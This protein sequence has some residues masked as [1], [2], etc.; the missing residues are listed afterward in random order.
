MASLALRH[1]TFAGDR[2]G[3]AQIVFDPRLTVVY[4][5]SD[6]GK[7]FVTDSLDYMLGARKLNVIPEAEGYSQILLGLTLPDGSV[8]TLMRGLNSPRIKVFNEDIRTL[9]Y[10]AADLSLSAQHSP[11]SS[12][13]LSR[14]LLE[15]IGLDG[16]LISTNATGGTK[17]LSFRDLLH[18]CL[19]NETRMI[20]K[21]PPA[22]RS[23]G[24]SGQTACR[25]AVKILLTGRGEPANGTRPTPGQRRVHKGKIVLLDD[26]VLALQRQLDPTSGN[27]AELTERLRR[28]LEHQDTGAVSLREV[29]A[30][31]AQAT[32]KRAHL[33]VE[34]AQHT[35]RRAEINNLLGR[36]E[37]LQRQYNSDLARLTMVTEA[38]S[39]LAYFNGEQRDCVLCGADPE[40]QRAHEGE[41][42][43]LHA[44]VETESLKTRQLLS[45]LHVTIEG[46]KEQR[47]EVAE[48]YRTSLATTESVD[49]V[50][51]RIEQEEL[52]PLQNTAAELMTA[53]SKVEHELGLHTRIQELE[54]VRATL[55]ADG[56]QPS[57]SPGGSIPAGTV[58]EFDRAIT[59]ALQSWQVPTDGDV[60][61][62]QYTGELFVGDRAR[63]AHGKGMRAVLH[64]AFVVALAE[65]CLRKEHSHPGFVVLDSPVLNYRQPGGPSPEVGQVPDNVTDRFY[66]DLFDS[67]RGQA[68][69]VENGDPPAGIAGQAQVYMFSR[70]PGGQRFGFFPLGPGPDAAPQP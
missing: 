10:R 11:R 25:S 23:S 69:V 2:R 45:D 15:R 54:D 32:A 67:F 60:F 24:T 27:Q 33:S 4:G 70:D 12:K 28:I 7:S 50:I 26:L 44:A 58:A 51:T 53:R 43:A 16:A 14:Y 63:T 48:Q 65:Y 22:L 34:I 57:G 20:S 38:N 68:V 18:L 42:T 66:Q 56:S 52:Q 61:Y 41:T 8:I 29:S 46:I 36:F 62:D 64:S 6:S 5:A 9:T 21:V 49:L 19:V 17:L 47:R 1:L 55:V 35:Q 30:R 39:L 37:L 13:N 59:R 3:D 31:H 40:H